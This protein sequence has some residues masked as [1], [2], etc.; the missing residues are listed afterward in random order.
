MYFL[1]IPW[2]LL[3][4]SQGNVSTAS[5]SRELVPNVTDKFVFG[6]ETHIS[7][8][9]STPHGKKKQKKPSSVLFVLVLSKIERKLTNKYLSLSSSNNHNNYISV[10]N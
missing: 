7:N 6:M 4:R 3:L 10:H 8:A 2:N 1:G 9:F 5:K